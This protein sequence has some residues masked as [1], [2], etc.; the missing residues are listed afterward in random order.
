MRPG[1]VPEVVV[2]VQAADVIRAVIAFFG[3]YQHAGCFRLRV[4]E[5]AFVIPVAQVKH[6]LLAPVQVQPGKHHDA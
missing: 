1:E 3:R 2:E 4:N 5:T 6:L